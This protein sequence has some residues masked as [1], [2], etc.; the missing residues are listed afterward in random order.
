VEPFGHHYQAGNLIGISGQWAYLAETIRKEKN[1]KPIYTGSYIAVVPLSRVQL[2]AVGR[3]GGCGDLIS[4]G[5]SLNSGYYVSRKPHDKPDSPHWFILLAADPNGNI[6]GTI[7]FVDHFGE[8]HLSQTFTG[9]AH[10]RF[11]ELTFSEAG[12]R[13]ADY[14]SSFIR[15]ND[16]GKWLKYISNGEQ[17]VFLPSI[18]GQD[19][20]KKLNAKRIRPR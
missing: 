6:S 12:L 20:Q 10:S 8:P 13:T 15:L 9:H 16:C 2:A 1:G 11:A 4:T 3:G 17:C 14:Q 7:A 18:G 5:E 19:I